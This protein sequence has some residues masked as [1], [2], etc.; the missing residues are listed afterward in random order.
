MNEIKK[1]DLTRRRS[2]RITADGVVQVKKLL[3][4]S[5]KTSLQL[6]ISTK[7]LIGQILSGKVDD[8]VTIFT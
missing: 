1:E 4:R 5:P 3:R 8:R 6:N 2:T 7:T